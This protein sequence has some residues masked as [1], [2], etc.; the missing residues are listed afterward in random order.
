[1]GGRDG[2]DKY[3]EDAIVGSKR[4]RDYRRREWGWDRVKR[5]GEEKSGW[6][7]GRE[8]TALL[9]PTPFTLPTT[10]QALKPGQN[11]ASSS[12]PH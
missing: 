6:E 10:H 7:E 11:L 5:E 8:K 1:M 3:G 2:I 9:S 12:L 4:D